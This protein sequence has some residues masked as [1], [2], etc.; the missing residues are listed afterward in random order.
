MDIIVKRQETTPVPVQRKRGGPPSMFR[1]GEK[2]RVQ[3]LHSEDN[4]VDVLLDSGVYLKHVPVRSK[5]WVIYQEDSEKDFNAGG[6]DLPPLHTRVFILM[7]TGTY[8]DCFVLC[9]LFSTPDKAEPFLAD[10]RERIQEIQTPG[11]WHITN[12]N[13]TGS[14][15]AVSPDKKTSR[16]LDYGSKDEPLDPPEL[17]EQLF[18][19]EDNDDPGLKL[20]VISGKSVEFEMFAEVMYKLFKGDFISLEEKLDKYYT[21]RANVYTDIEKNEET[22]VQRNSLHE[23]NNTDIYSATPIGIKGTETQL[24]GDVLQVFF[25]DLAKAWNQYP[26]IIPPVPWP[27]GLPVPPAPPIINMA[28]NGIKLQTLRAIATAKASCAKTLK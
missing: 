20:D 25:D 11:W 24:G 22:R 12:D 6:R 27:P 4:T 5:G 23:S 16:N 17:H 9:S 7:P 28:L 19:D 21:N 10:D 18:H 15:K 26:V 13:D 3:E 1:I 2:G 8:Y 14:H